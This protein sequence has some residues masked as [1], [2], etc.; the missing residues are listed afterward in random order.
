MDLFELI[1]VILRRWLIVVP[2]AAAT[3]VLAFYVQTSVPAELEATGY[4]RLETRAFA[5]DQGTAQELDPFA[6]AAQASEAV[7]ST[8]TIDPRGGGNYVVTVTGGDSTMAG[9]LMDEAV[10]ALGA[11]LQSLQDVSEVPEA[12]RAELRRVAPDEVMI[13]DTGTAVASASLFLF[14]PGSSSVNPYQP[15]ASTGRLLQVSVSGDTGRR[16]FFEAMG[17]DYTFEVGQEARDAAALIQIATIGPDEEGVIESF[18]QVMHLMQLELDARQDRADVPP[19]Q[20]L[21]MT[22]VD[23]PVRASDQSAPVNRASAGIVALG[24]LLTLGVVFGW[25][26]RSRR[27]ASRNLAA[28]DTDAPD[29]PTD[30]SPA[31]Q[32]PQPEPS[33]ASDTG[34]DRSPTLPPPISGDAGSPR[35]VNGNGAPAGEPS[36]VEAR[37]GREREIYSVHERFPDVRPTPQPRDTAIQSQSS[38][39]QAEGQHD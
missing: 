16:A 38:Q 15:N 31:A 1:R 33:P 32:T 3:L 36:R 21:S 26:A 23:A 18:Y 25:E 14:V 7:D 6:L 13:Q 22:V 9:A 37:P 34:R 24:G 27:K 17:P 5:G 4:V 11:S 12:E 20:R 28:E 10:V 30:A 39:G 2:M 8:V 35:P 29:P 19:A